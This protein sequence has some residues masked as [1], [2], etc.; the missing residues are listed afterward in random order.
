VNGI[1]AY[2][3]LPVAASNGIDE[4][5]VLNLYR[6]FSAISA[7]GSNCWLIHPVSPFA[8]HAAMCAAVS[9]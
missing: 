1:R 7:L 5:R 6:D 9:L 3:E 8:F 2:N 4:A